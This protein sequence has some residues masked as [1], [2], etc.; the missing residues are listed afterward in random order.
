M[1]QI[2]RFLSARSWGLWAGV[3]LGIVLGMAL[4]AVAVRR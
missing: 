1:N 2:G 4:I 3:A